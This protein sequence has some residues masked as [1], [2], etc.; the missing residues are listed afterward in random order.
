MLFFCIDS[1]LVPNDGA[2]SLAMS[3]T[4]PEISLFDDRLRRTVQ[5]SPIHL[6]S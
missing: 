6:E 5:P 3:T 2:E 1:E 4:G